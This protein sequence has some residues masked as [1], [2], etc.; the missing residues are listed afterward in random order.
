MR[1]P[2]REQDKDA[3][4]EDLKNLIAAKREAAFKRERR[5]FWS[6]CLCMTVFSVLLA[7]L[8]YGLIYQVHHYHYRPPYPR[9]SV[10]APPPPP[11]REAGILGDVAAAGGLVLFFG[12]AVGTVWSGIRW[13]EA[14]GD[15]RRHFEIA[16]QPKGPPPGRGR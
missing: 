10:G 4:V 16:P 12:S 7:G 11:S 5:A 2:F 1:H 6:A 14:V 8:I 15:R 9:L 3:L 13:L